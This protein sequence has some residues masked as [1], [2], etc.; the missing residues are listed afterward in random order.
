M[1]LSTVVAFLG[2]IAIAGCVSTFHRIE[3]APPAKAK[4]SSA[5][6]PYLQVREFGVSHK[7]VLSHFAGLTQ[8]AVTVDV[9]NRSS[10]PITL[11][12]SKAALDIEHICNPTRAHVSA[13]ASGAGNLPDR[14]DERSAN[15]PP[16]TIGRDDTRAEVAWSILHGLATLQAS[17]RLRP[18]HLHARLDIAH[19][20][21]TQETH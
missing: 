7:V 11:D 21:L 9:R 4:S 3:I 8:S 1:R 6:S 16:V 2:S 12:V 19:R 20:M 17:G 15:R 13:V 10:A 14:I 5:D 18:T